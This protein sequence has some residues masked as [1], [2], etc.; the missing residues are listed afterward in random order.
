MASHN[1]NF[2]LLWLIDSFATFFYTCCAVTDFMII[3]ITQEHNEAWLMHHRGDLHHKR[4]DAVMGK[5]RSRYCAALPG[6]LPTTVS[7]E[8]GLSM[9]ESGLSM[10]DIAA[11]FELVTESLQRDSSSI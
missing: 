4:G 5:V 8:S 1:L 6:E 9:T 7:G 3:M 2:L 10:G 11:T